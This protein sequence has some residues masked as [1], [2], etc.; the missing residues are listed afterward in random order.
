VA[1]IAL[2]EVATELTG[3]CVVPL[4]PVAAGTGILWRTSERSTS[5][6]LL[7]AFVI[8]CQRAR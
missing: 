7:S 1:V 3:A 6:S 4:V 8:A 5:I 2:G